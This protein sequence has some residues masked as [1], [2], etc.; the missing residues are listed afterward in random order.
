MN[1]KG[2][3]DLANA[4][5]FAE[6]EHAGDEDYIAR[7]KKLFDHCKTGRRRFSSPLIKSTTQTANSVGT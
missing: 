2:M 7:S 1:D 4:D 3:F 6:R 5:K